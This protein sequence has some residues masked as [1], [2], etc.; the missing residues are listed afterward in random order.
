MIDRRSFARLLSAIVL[1]L[2]VLPL[3]AA[4][5]LPGAD[6]LR[7]QFEQLSPEQRQAAARAL[8]IPPE[9]ATAPSRSAEDAPP[10][11]ETSS[12]AVSPP[13]ATDVIRALRAGDTV[14]LT[15]RNPPVSETTPAT[16]KRLYRLDQAGAIVLPDSGRIVLA[17]LSEREA[18]ERLSVEAGIAGRVVAVQLLPVDPELKLFGLDLFSGAPSTFSPAVDIPVPAEYIIGPGDSVIVQLFGK[19]NNQYELTITRDGALL[20][21]GIGPLSVAGLTFARLQDEI[22]TRVQRQLSGV[23]ASVTLGRI[24]SIRVFVLG[25]AD[26]PGSY[27]VSGMSTLTNALLV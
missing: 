12:G 2:S 3:Q 18:V 4:G 13:R 21:P 11:V 5:A 22:Q 17:G 10:G 23:S 16:E 7:Q 15:M 6:Q 1:S 19:E 20:F 9:P 27:V 25:D 26:T 14:L 24:R 8:G